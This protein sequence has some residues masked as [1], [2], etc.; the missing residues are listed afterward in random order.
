MLKANIISIIG[1]VRWGMDSRYANSRDYF[2]K[3]WRPNAILD[4]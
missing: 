1:I 3:R 4:G 2:G